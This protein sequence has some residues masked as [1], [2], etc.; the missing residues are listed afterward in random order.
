M[1]GFVFPGLNEGT[2]G[3]GI[4]PELVHTWSRLDAPLVGSPAGTAF[5]GVW[6][7]GVPRRLLVALGHRAGRAAGH[8]LAGAGPHRGA[9]RR[10]TSTATVRPWPERGP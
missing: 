4:A 1:L 2:H 6:C 8:R 9:Y 5:V 7:A 3:G 10:V